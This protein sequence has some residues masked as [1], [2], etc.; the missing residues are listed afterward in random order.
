MSRLSIRTWVP[1]RSHEP[2]LAKTCIYGPGVGWSWAPWWRRIGEPATQE[3]E[4]RKG[5]YGG[6]EG[7]GEQ[8]EFPFLTQDITW[9]PGLVVPYRLPWVTDFLLDSC[10]YC[11]SPHAGQ[12]GCDLSRFTLIVSIVV[13]CSGFESYRHVLNKSM[14]WYCFRSCGVDPGAHWAILTTLVTRFLRSHASS[15]AARVAST[16]F[17]RDSPPK[18]GFTT[19]PLGTI[20]SCVWEKCKKFL[21]K[22][23]IMPKWECS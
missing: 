21:Q 9:S 19:F 11:S 16:Y 4:G 2:T 22:E 3:E 14:W 15:F 7:E 17:T 20:P 6:E 18:G 10:L 8:S 23:G 1:F 12:S 5:G 13:F